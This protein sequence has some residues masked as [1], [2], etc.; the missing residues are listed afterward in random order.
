MNYHI[1]GRVQ[2]EAIVFSSNEGLLG[3][4]PGA[5]ELLER[6][7]SR[8]KKKT[9][10]SKNKMTGILFGTGIGPGDPELMTLKAVRL[11]REMIR[12]QYQERNRK[13]ALP[14]RLLFRQC[15]NWQKKSSLL[16]Q[17]R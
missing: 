1:E 8:K 16:F 9:E 2:T 6:C 15:R 7:G 17:C 5:G 13:R 11:I 3:E 12:L 14:T 4:T 10:K